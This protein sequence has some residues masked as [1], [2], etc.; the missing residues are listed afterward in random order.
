MRRPV[1][2]LLILLLFFLLTQWWLPGALAWGLETALQQSYPEARKIHVAVTG[3]PAVKVLA[4][5]V[6]RLEVRAEKMPLGSVTAENFQAGLENVR[7]NVW[8]L[9]TKRKV[10]LTAGRKKITV[11]ITEQAINH[12]LQTSGR[13]PLLKRPYLTVQEDNVK[14]EGAVI[15]VGQEIP[16]TINGRLTLNNGRLVFRPQNVTLDGKE[17]AST[18]Q[19]RILN[20]IMFEVPLG[21]M[22]VDMVFTR[23]RQY[24]GEIILTAA[25]H[26][27]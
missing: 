4:G 13:L 18:V 24:P 25:G 22:P 8:H 2:F 1:G 12:Y 9:L 14:L 16:V 27:T 26:S 5:R 23:L 15:L 21:N 19:R 20:R 6:D 10:V 7:I 3:F 17:F 11:T